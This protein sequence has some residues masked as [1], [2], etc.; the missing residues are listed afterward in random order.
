MAPE[1]KPKRKPHEVQ[2][3]YTPA[4]SEL[5]K[6][7]KQK[8][9]DEARQAAADA[10]QARAAARAES[11]AQAQRQREI[12][13]ALDTLAAGVSS[14]AS[15][16]PIVE[17]EG[18]SGPSFADYG[19]VVGNI[20]YRAWIT[21]DNAVN[22]LA[23]TKARIVVSR[24]GRVVSAEIVGPCGEKDVDKSVERALRAVTSLPP[25]PAG[26]HDDQRTFLINFDLKAKVDAG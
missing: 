15:D 18:D 21:P 12:K 14:K 23:Q 9:T 24:D 1:P 5:H 7:K 6:S 20:F 25:F 22:R 17:N 13:A 4:S 19:T 16:H 3:D 8:E 10:E 11:R 26:A 2:V